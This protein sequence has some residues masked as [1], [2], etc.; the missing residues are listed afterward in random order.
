MDRAEVTIVGAGVIGLAIAAELAQSVESVVVV[1][2]HNSFGRE[3]SSRNSE[4]VH[5]GLYYP[6]GS[7]KA[8]LCVDGAERL[9]SCC[10]EHSIP[11]SRL[12][13]LIVAV[14]QSEVAGLGE[15]LERGTLNGVQGLRLLGKEEVER[16]EPEVI[17]SAAIHSPGTGIV[18][19]H[20][21]MSH[22]HRKAASSG[23]VFS[24]S[25]EVDRIEKQRQGYLIGLKGEDYAFFSDAVVNAAGLASDRV[26][27]MAGIDADKEGYRL[28][29]CKGSYF[30]Y[31]KKS[32][33]SLLVYSAPLKDLKGLGVHA[34]PD[35]GGRLRLG[36][37]AEDVDSIEYG[38]DQGK[39]DAFYESASRMIRG[40]DREAFSPDMSGIRP[41][42][43]G[44]GIRDFI[45]THEAD[46]GLEGLID[47][48]GIE[49]PGLTS[50]LA[51]ARLVAGMVREVLR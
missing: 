42:V 22:L 21:L 12:G 50:A 9:Y 5:S 16:I 48:I 46:K 38:V 45:I 39:R 8:R 43:R 49:S 27:E 41:K 44:E 47:L 13:K 20:S 6:P 14:G 51:I 17:A 18:D 37:D 4:V 35:L 30:S 33:V 19:S 11:C 32:P 1:E 15:L 25:S 34:T 29:F 26:A 36:P 3:T 7:L 2:R 24:F 23:A 28:S 40:L 31:G 10:E